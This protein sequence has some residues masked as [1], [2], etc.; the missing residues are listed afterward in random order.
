MALAP[1]VCV[2]SSCICADCIFHDRPTDERPVYPPSTQYGLPR[3]VVVLL[4][5]VFVC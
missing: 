1:G 2:E 5:H 4:P 3:D